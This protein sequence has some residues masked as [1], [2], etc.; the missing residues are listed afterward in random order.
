MSMNVP[1]TLHVKTVVTVPTQMAH[2]AAFAQVDGKMR[3]VQQVEKQ[4][5][6]FDDRL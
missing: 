2:T 3:T 1:P 4:N 5:I 6:P